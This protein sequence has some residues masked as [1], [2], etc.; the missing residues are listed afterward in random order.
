MDTAQAGATDSKTVTFRIWR[1]TAPGH[2]GRYEEFQ[3]PVRA[4]APTSSPA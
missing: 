3:R 1:R 2:A 4:R